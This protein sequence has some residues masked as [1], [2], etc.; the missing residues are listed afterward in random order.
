MKTTEKF[1][2]LTNNEKKAL[3][4]LKK[5][6]LKLYPDAKLILFGSKVR[7]DFDEESDVD[8]LVV[9]PELNFDKKEIIWDISNEI[10]LKYDTSLS[11]VLI[12]KNKFHPETI[13]LMVLPFY[14]NVKEDG[15]YL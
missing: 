3:K 9:L 13:D 11:V 8:V 2:Y 15:S 10:N 12:D 6:V 7:G 5:E 1:K 14:S 4:E